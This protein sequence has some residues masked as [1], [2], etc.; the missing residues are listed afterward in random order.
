M[1]IAERRAGVLLLTLDRPEKR[2]SL[3]PE[4][5]GKL[6]AALSEADADDG[7]RVV[8]VTGAGSAFSAGLDLQHLSAL[9]E[10]G[11]VAYMHSAFALFRMVYELRRPVL[12][13]VNGPAMAGGFDLA[14]FCDLRFCATDARFAQ[15]EILLGLTQIMYPLYKVIGLSR[16]KA[17][18]LTGE[19]ITADEA[20]RIGLVDRVYPPDELLP[21]SLRFAESLAGR[22]PE[23]LFDTKRLS[24]EVVEMDTGSAMDRMFDTITTRL[25]S[26][27]HRNA[28]EAYVQRLR[29]PR[30]GEGSG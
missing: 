22:P 10:A 16:A 4:L 25:R 23:A 17:L 19:A 20:F 3:H 30:P 1:L 18:A 26:E 2:N 13:A 8:V 11:R 9:D 6:K 14:A 15:T 12:A 5:I 24:R 21:A 29:R 27:E 7:V 28:L